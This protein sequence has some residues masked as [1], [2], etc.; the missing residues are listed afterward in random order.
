MFGNHK[1][2]ITLLA[3]L[4]LLAVAQT[5][6]FAALSMVGPPS[7]Q[8]G[9][10]IYYRDSNGVALQVGL[11]GDGATGPSVYDPVDP[12]NP[13]SV[14]IGFGAE[15][16]YWS[17]D[18]SM[19]MRGDNDAD[20]VLA[21]EAA[22]F[23]EE[24][25]PGDQFVFGRVRI[26]ID[27]PVAGDYKVIHPYGTQIFEDVPAGRRAINFT[28]DIG[29]FPGFEGAL[30][31]SIG[32]FLTAVS[33]APP[34]GFVGNPQIDQTV[35]G[36]PYGT[37]YFRVEGPQGSNLDGQGNDFIQTNLF[38]ISGMI[39]TGTPI[40]VDRTTYKRSV[41]GQVDV[42]ATSLPTAQVRF[43][44]GAQIPDTLMSADGNGHFFG[45]FYMPD[46]NSLPAKI[47]VTANNPPK[48]TPVTVES[49]LVD[50]VNITMAEYDRNTLTLSIL[51]SSSDAAVPPTLTVE[52]YGVMTNG[53]LVIPN[54]IA[55]PAKVTVTSSAGGKSER[56][57]ELVVA[58]A[59]AIGNL[60]SKPANTPF[61]LATQ[62]V[63]TVVPGTFTDGYY[64]IEQPDRAAGIKVKAY[65]GQPE[66]AL[67]THVTL[68]GIL[69]VDANGERYLDATDI[70]SAEP[71]T[72]LQPVGMMTKLVQGIGLDATGLLVKTWGKV[73]WVAPNG[74]YFSMDDG[75]GKVNSMGKPGIPIL[76]SSL[77]TPLANPPAVGD[78][79]SVVGIASIHNF[80]NGVEPVVKTRGDGDIAVFAP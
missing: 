65:A 44:G 17:G 5:V 47:S 19:T 22:F 28:Q 71:G 52:G 66:L 48:N 55:P 30:V 26:R 18:S 63:V 54:L 76:L 45:S 10:P 72:P 6:A 4:I 60:K 50:F 41:D 12:G 49:D 35:T 9:F 75:S 14:Q 58:P 2:L 11:V 25:Q 61:N 34:E 51:A 7:P 39:Y 15:A 32:P 27:T 23:N 43:S 73:T 59:L 36:S 40:T 33:P 38:A 74:S 77:A 42:F 62:Q 24:P 79:V 29:S 3:G 13:F 68:S 1:T 69:T 16:F 53:A 20:L 64:Y 80:G 46:A 67:G 21:L 70:T 78:F 37:N 56:P 8:H 57:I 31:S